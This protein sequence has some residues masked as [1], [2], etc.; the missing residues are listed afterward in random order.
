MMKQ[1]YPRKSLLMA[2]VGALLAFCLVANTQ[3]AQE[4]N[5]NEIQIAGSFFHAQGSDVGT[6][7]LDVSYGY[8]L[9]DRWQIGLGQTL[10]YS[11]IDDKEDIWTASTIPFVHYHF[12]GL[13]LNDSFQ[14]FIGA[15]AGAVYNEDDVT[16]TAGPAIGFK[17]FLSDKTFLVVKYRYEWFFDD[18]KVGDVTDTSDGNHVG[19]IGLGFVW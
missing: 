6:L 18:L 11:F 9:T 10:G 2:A 16:G 19:T 1:L 5:E 15:F 14:P 12:R 8:Y 3:A 7:T 17:S 13:S 4:A